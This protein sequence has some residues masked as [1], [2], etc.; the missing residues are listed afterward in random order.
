MGLN[1]KEMIIVAGFDKLLVGSIR[2]L[3]RKKGYN[4]FPCCSLDSVTT[5][6]ETLPSC[7]APVSM[8]IFEPSILTHLSGQTVLKFRGCSSPA[9]FV[10][11]GNTN[12]IDCAQKNFKII[13]PSHSRFDLYQFQLIQLLN[14]H[15]L[16]TFYC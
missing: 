2:R 8:V 12:S 4:S 9:C 3:L 1:M 7:D 13:S 10:L 5:E 11:A 15:G 6:L 14:E 16:Q